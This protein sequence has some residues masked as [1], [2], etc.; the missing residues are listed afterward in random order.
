MT[1]VKMR[2]RIAE[3]IGVDQTDTTYDNKI[4]EWVNNSY[5][6]IAAK[7]NW[8]WLVKN[9]V[10]QTVADITTGTVAIA[11]GGTALT[12]SVAP[13]SSSVANDYQIQFAGANNWY[14]I[15]A[16]VGGATTATLGQAYLGT[17]LT[18]GTYILRKMYYSLPSDMDRIIDV[19]QVTFPTKMEYQDIRM[20]DSLQPYPTATG[21]PYVYS[22]VGLDSSKNWRMFF[23]PSPSTAI[24][25]NIRYY[26]RI[27]ELSSDSDTPLMPDPWDE[28]ILFR[29]LAIYGAS[30]IDDTRRKDYKDAF[31]EIYKDMQKKLLPTSDQVVVKI[32]WDRVPDYPKVIPYPSNY[33][34]V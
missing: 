10:L 20:F 17:T 3:L 22:L 13:S 19:R 4:K 8:P 33:P 18:V 32:P 9:Y 7:E 14:E 27:T 2:Q 29:A 23:F 11:S 21:S 26:Q 15:T 12:F 34:R 25:V 5:K 24:N 31:D 28:S 16:H 30:F 6:Y 1:Y